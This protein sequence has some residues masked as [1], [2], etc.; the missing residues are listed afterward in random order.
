MKYE[1]HYYR[2]GAFGVVYKADWRN[3]ECVV[4]QMNFNPNDTTALKDFLKEAMHMK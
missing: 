2:I 4:K 1:N 3:S